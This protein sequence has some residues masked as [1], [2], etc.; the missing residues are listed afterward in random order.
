MKNAIKK[1]ALL[2]KN[3]VVRHRA[4][5]AVAAT[6]VTCYA[7][8]RVTV[9]QWYEFLEE[10]GIDKMEFICPEYFAEMLNS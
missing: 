7:L 10:K 1:K 8:H 6:L 2:T 9:E 5:Y 4:K 3:H